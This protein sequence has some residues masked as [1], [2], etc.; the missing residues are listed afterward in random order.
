M[1]LADVVRFACGVQVGQGCRS[2]LES[3]P[4]QFLRNL[5]SHAVQ[6]AGGD[7]GKQGVSVGGGRHHQE[8][9]EGR[10]TLLDT[11]LRPRVRLDSQVACAYVG[12]NHRDAG[13]PM[14]LRPVHADNNSAI[15]TSDSAP[16]EVPHA[17]SLDHWIW[18]ISRISTRTAHE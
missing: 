2:V 10:V 13:R 12:G 18:P 6:T 16:I 3:R 11:L 8:H 15:W 7:E 9:R 14:N 17:T 1:D 5:R 4:R